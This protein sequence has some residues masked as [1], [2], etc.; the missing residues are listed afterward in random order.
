LDITGLYLT[1]F[2]SFNRI[3]DFHCEL[4]Q[5][6]YENRSHASLKYPVELEHFIA[7]G[8]YQAIMSYSKNA[9]S[10]TFA[11]FTERIVDTIR[12]EIALSIQRSYDSLST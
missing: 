12:H 4:E 10:S 11:W 6:P 3:V 2:L 8:N 9:P 1:Y 7:E 5:V